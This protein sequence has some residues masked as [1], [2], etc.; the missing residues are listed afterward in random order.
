MTTPTAGTA[1]DV[2]TQ[3]EAEARASRINDVSYELALDL[4]GGAA[5][6]RGDVTIRF[7]VVEVGPHTFL[8]FKGKTIEWFEVNGREITP[9]WDGYHLTLPADALAPQ[10]TVRIRYENDYDHTGDG[11]H[12]FIDP[13]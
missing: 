1:R 8:D 10:N 5:T 3:A 11:F 9:E 6:Y 2:L 12:Q 13:E 4:T 7:Q